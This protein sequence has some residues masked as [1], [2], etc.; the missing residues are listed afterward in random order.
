MNGPNALTLHVSS[1]KGRIL[2]ILRKSVDSNRVA[3]SWSKPG[4]FNL[5][6]EHCASSRFHADAAGVEIFAPKQIRLLHQWMWDEA[7]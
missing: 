6:S 2:T 4:R 7:I 5:V 3:R 1:E